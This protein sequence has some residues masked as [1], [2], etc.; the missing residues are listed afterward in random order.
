MVADTTAGTPQGFPATLG[1]T[2]DPNW[3]SFTPPR[4][5][6]EVA[7]GGGIRFAQT[8]ALD[9]E[10]VVSESVDAM[11]CQLGPFKLWQGM[12]LGGDADLAGYAGTADERPPATGEYEV[13]FTITPEASRG[14]RQLEQQ[15]VDDF[16]RAFALTLGAAADIV[17]DL[18]A[19]RE[20]VFADERSA[21]AELA[22][23]LGQAELEV[24][25]LPP[26][27][28]IDLD[29][30]NAAFQKALKD[31][32]YEL[33]DLS[34]LRDPQSGSHEPR[35]GVDRIDHLPARTA[36]FQQPSEPG[37]LP[38]CIISVDTP[39][40]V[41]TH[42][43]EE[44]ITMD[45][46]RTVRQLRPRDAVDDPFV[47]RNAPFQ[48]GDHVVLRDLVSSPAYKD[49]PQRE[50]QLFKGQKAKVDKVEKLRLYLSGIDHEKADFEILIAASKVK[51]DDSTTV[52][53]IVDDKPTAVTPIEMD[54]DLL[55]ALD[56]EP[57]AVT[58]IEMDPD[59][60]LGLDDE[61][62]V[63]TE[64]GGGDDSGSREP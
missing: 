58:P 2:G 29:A 4:I 35:L 9:S 26:D 45:R 62:T 51:R 21:L 60:L 48:K 13:R 59:L 20:S 31:L 23:R 56:D 46:L 32:L 50:G 22:V 33:F 37:Q 3:A 7:E 39:S 19:D 49:E 54:P 64:P 42:T 18:H 5:Q 8:V 53:M 6:W 61:P 63:E 27:G 10:A 14:I 34:K 44:L 30:T 40:I 17:N 15:H 24:P 28:N 52:E 25:G 12:P 55:L 11:D 41:G 1:V 57:T 36:T 16:R 43:S 47:L 38:R